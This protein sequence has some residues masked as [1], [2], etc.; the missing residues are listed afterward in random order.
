[1]ASR[2]H[3]AAI[4]RFTVRRPLPVA[5]W[6]E[7]QLPGRTRALGLQQEDRSS[8]RCWSGC[9]WRPIGRT[10]ALAR[11]QAYDSLW[12]RDRTP[13]MSPT[14]SSSKSRRKAVLPLSWL[15]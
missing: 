8:G 2:V 10:I 6:L 4:I 7:A 1:M 13:P 14:S 5:M 3:V 9:C 12:I 15:P 11:C